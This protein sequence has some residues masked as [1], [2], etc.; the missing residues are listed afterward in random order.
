MTTVLLVGTGEVGGRAA[1]LLAGIPG[2]TE[3]LLAGRRPKS[4]VE[5]ADALGPPV[6]SATF[7]PG[8]PL[9]DGIAVVATAV[10]SEVDVAIAAAAVES[11]VP[12]VSCADSSNSVDGLFALDVA[13]TERRVPLVAGCGLAPGLSDVLAAH[14]VGAL[15]EVDE[16]HIARAGVTGPASLATLRRE[17]R[18][19][20]LEWRSGVW[21]TE[22]QRGPE[23][24]W[25]PEP[26]GARETMSVGSGIRLLVRAFPRL[27]AATIR[28]C[29][30]LPRQARRFWRSSDDGAGAA[31][32]TVRGRRGH[33]CES[34]VYGVVERMATAAATV[35]ALGAAS[36]AGLAP[37]VRREQG[38]EAGVRS[39]AEV[40]A[41]VPFLAELARMGVTAA[42]FEGVD[43]A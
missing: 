7:C 29:E 33:A 26:V 9:P 18:E 11:G 31:L 8:D 43:V 15:D 10:P 4:V 42:A 32:V 6:R 13:A 20:A 22:R 35:L 16:I 1:R 12:F 23:L 21:Q 14:G 36:L 39:L 34:L 28:M 5:L 24:V 30:P 2:V 38:V 40:V 41:P 25:F 27:E 19:P 3:V 37:E 17:L